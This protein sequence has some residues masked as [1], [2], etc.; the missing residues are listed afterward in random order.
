[1]YIKKSKIRK[2]DTKSKKF[3]QSCRLYLA[4]DCTENPNN[5][6]LKIPE[7]YLCQT[8]FVSKHTVTLFSSRII[9]IC[10]NTCALLLSFSNSSLQ[11]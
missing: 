5:S 2:L 4:L 1:M 10:A 8:T 9:L 3:E 7:E 11:P 6:D